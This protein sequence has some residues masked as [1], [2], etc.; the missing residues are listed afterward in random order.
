[1]RGPS[2]RVHAGLIIAFDGHEHRLLRDGCLVHRDGQVTYVGPR[3]DVRADRVLDLGPQLVAPGFVSIHGHL[4]NTP[5]TKSL[6][7]DQGRPQLWMSAVYEYLYPVIGA[8]SERSALAAVRASLLEALRSG[9][10][11]VVE[12]GPSVEELTAAI[13]DLAEDAG[14]RMYLGP[15]Y[16]SADYEVV[17][18]RRIEYQW[19][20]AEEERRQLETCV[21]TIR[22]VERRDGL[23]RGML[24]PA[25]ADTC[26]PELLRETARIAEE[27]DVPVQIHAGQAVLEFHEIV[28]RHGCTPVA[29][30]ADSGLLSPRTIVGHCLFTGGHSWLAYPDEGDLDL[31]TA[32]GAH[33]A[34]CP[35]VFARCGIGLES[36]S[37]YRRA[38]INLALGTDTFPQSMLHEMRVASTM[39]KTMERDPLAASAREVF[40]AATLGGARALG[41]EDLGR[42][43]PGARAD[44]V[45]YRTDTLGMAPLRDPLLNLVFSAGPEDVDRVVVDGREV[46]AGG[47]APGLPE[48]QVSRE[49]QAA[50]ED[51]WR[52]LPAHDPAGRTADE[53]SPP[54][55]RDWPDAQGVTA[56]ADGT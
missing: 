31:L 46:L 11:T 33:V 3:R 47:L 36:F 17:D 5:L 8:T 30:L 10:T 15:M 32:S 51:V 38:G 50:A 19:R 29:L 45:C 35:W 43:A 52:A 53:L 4:S 18:G 42:L 26:R 41:R 13:A 9:I 24:A 48:A 16:R 14:V 2:P 40:D 22:N 44:F 34:H 37:R 21:R 25:Q 55:L 7:E 6:R 39:G 27:L 1:L 56:G 20:S 12:L 23:V 28:R 54:C 49:L